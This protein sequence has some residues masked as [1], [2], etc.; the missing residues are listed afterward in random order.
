MTATRL[1]ADLHRLPDVGLSQGTFG[2]W[3]NRYEARK[4]DKEAWILMLLEA[5]ERARTTPLFTEP[6]RLRVEVYYPTAKVPDVDAISGSGIKPLIDLL[7]PLHRVGRGSRGYVGWIAN[8]RLIASLSVE[9]F[10]DASR[11]PLTR[12]RME[13][14][15]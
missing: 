6:V 13:A 4:E 7:E 3:R 5:G 9:R 15:G 14:V 10:T 2:H 8:D 12:L 1:S 11:A